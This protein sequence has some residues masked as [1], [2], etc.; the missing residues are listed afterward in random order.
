MTKAKLIKKDEIL[1]RE[2]KIVAQRSQKQAVRQ[3]VE[4]VNQWIEKQQAKHLDPR[5]A[6]AA[7]FAHP[8]T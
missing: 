1:K 7:L 3:T 8:Q 5:A 2:P 6:F 4:V